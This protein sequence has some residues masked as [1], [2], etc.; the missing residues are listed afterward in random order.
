MTKD[1][2]YLTPYIL[3]AIIWLAT[4]AI[5]LR[6]LVKKQSVTSMMAWLMIVYVFPVV[7][8]LAYIC[9][10][11][12]NLGKKRTLLFDQVKPRFLEWYQKLAGDKQLTNNREM[13]RYGEIFDLVQNR[14]YIPCIVGN[15]L[16]LINQTDAIYDQIIKDIENAQHDINMVFYIWQSG[17]WVSKVEEA[18]I[19]AKKRGVDVRLIL[20]SMGSR[21]FLASNNCQSMRKAGIEIVECLK[22]NLLRVFFSRIDVRMHRK[23][24]VIDNQVSYT[25]SQNMVDPRYFKQD[26]NVGEWVDVM[27]R[28]EG[29]VSS[30]L[31]SLHAL[32]WQM[33]TG[34]A[35][36]LE[37][38]KF[39]QSTTSNSQSAQLLAIGP[40]LPDDLMEQTLLQGIFDAK[41]SITITSPYFV[42]SHK[43]A[44]ALQIV[45]WRGV[46]VKIIL[47]AKNDSTM[48][49]WASRT[50]FDDLLNA[51]V[52]IYQF[53]GGLLHT[54]SVLIDN[55]LSMVGTVNMDI[56]S[57]SLNFE[58]MLLVEDESFATEVQNLQSEYLS[59]CQILDKNTWL[60]RPTYRKIIEKLF[61]FFSP[62]L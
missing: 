3:S 40:G 19:N 41:H 20:D 56:R 62:L 47:P 21:T 7:G 14:S 10:G 28:I 45:A 43:V 5:T 53:E 61:F 2:D 27:I 32:D 55:R 22:A 51:G 34:T 39:N 54:K 26:S 44:E 58:L 46:N 17:G 60:I 30:V 12:I 1:I 37:F 57:F 6:L 16:H 52:E 23:I 33:E 38:P 29:G 11:E 9:F 13:S 42:P 49:E 59:K 4:V 48:V 18:L 8:I 24:I 36:P 15:Q 35:L 31:N 25:G 50:F